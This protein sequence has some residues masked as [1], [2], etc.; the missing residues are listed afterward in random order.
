[1]SIKNILIN[2]QQYKTLFQNNINNNL[3]IQKLWKKS[4]ESKIFYNATK[5]P[6]I[7]LK[8][9]NLNNVDFY[10]I[11]SELKA[12]AFIDNL[13]PNIVKVIKSFICDQ[14]LNSYETTN[15]TIIPLCRKNNDKK[16]ISL[17]IL[18]L[19]FVKGESLNGKKINFEEFKD[20][21]VQL[22]CVFFFLTALKMEISDTNLDNII[23]ENKEELLDYTILF[24]E[25][26]KILTFHKITIIDLDH[27]KFN[28]NI[29]S[30]Y[31]AIQEYIFNKDNYF[32]KFINKF[33]NNNI[34]IK[35]NIIILKNYLFDNINSNITNKNPIDIIM[36]IK[37]FK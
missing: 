26:G 1:M 24:G 7:L 17:S 15:Q 2:N 25:K 9:R 11:S 27:I 3:N 14:N 37:E 10:S 12:F 29:P 16:C 21:L 6:T 28:I 19:K 30:K 18:A 36:I 34:N 32:I 4:N 13:C 31:K 35:N 5:N 23:Y 22:Y 8:V 33:I 20:I